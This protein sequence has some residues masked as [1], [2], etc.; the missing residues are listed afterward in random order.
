[1]TVAA[2]AAGASLELGACFEKANV[3]YRHPL[4]RAYFLTQGVQHLIVHAGAGWLV[5]TIIMSQGQPDLR[6]PP[7]QMWRLTLGPGCAAELTCRDDEQCLRYIRPIH[8]TDFPYDP[9]ELWLDGSVLGL[10][11]E[12]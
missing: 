8:W 11:N 5:D 2:R 1:M 6:L 9:F 7:F 4:K 3:L 10:P 12:T